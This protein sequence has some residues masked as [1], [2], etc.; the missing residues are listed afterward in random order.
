MSESTK[1]MSLSK[2]KGAAGKPNFVFLLADDMGFGTISDDTTPFMASLASKAVTLDNYYSQET[3]TPARAALLTGRYPI[4]IGVQFYEQ[5]VA[6]KGGLPEGETTIADILQNEGYTTYMLGKW[7]LGNASPRQLPTSR[8]FDYFLGFLDAYNHY[9]TKLNPDFPDFMDFMYA[10]STCYYKYDGDD[11][12]EYS[13][14]IFQNAAVAS[15]DG[16]DFDESPMF[17]YL[18]MQAARAPFDDLSDDHEHGMDDSYL[19]E[20]GQAGVQ[21]YITKNIDGTIQQQYFKAVAVMDKA[22]ENIYNAL[23]DKGVLDNTYI[24][25]ASDNGGCPTA[26]GR[27]YPLRGTKGSLFEGGTKVEAFIYSPL[28]SSKVQGSTYSNLFHV[29]DWLPT[30]LSMAEVGYVRYGTYA[31]NGVSHLKAITS[32]DKAPR[33]YLLYNYYYDPSSPTV[34]LWNGKAFAVRNERYKL[35]HTYDSPMS[36]AWYA[37]NQKMNFDDDLAD[38]D[39][40]AQFSAVRGGEFKYFLFDLKT[41]PTETTNLY[42]T[43][44][45]YKAIQ[46]ELY[47]ALT[48]LTKTAAAYCDSGFEEGAEPAWKENDNYIVP[49]IDETDRRLDAE[50]PS[51]SSPSSPSPRGHGGRRLGVKYPSNCG[52]WSGSDSAADADESVKSIQSKNMI[53]ITLSPKASVGRT[54]AGLFSVVARTAA[55]KTLA[56]LYGTETVTE[57]PEE[58]AESVSSPVRAYARGYQH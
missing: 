40:C 27:N 10:D 33:S 50:A 36:G 44:A 54:S 35:M 6:N 12:A 41:D 56:A 22:M 11:L 34:D 24:L 21:K 25:F 1:I 30:V 8:G 48:D 19:A 39:G 51:A 37:D 26:G 9:W 3:C 13:T 17:L 53:S 57:E 2:N 28:L 38:F 4:S 5:E 7:N 20:V 49:W 42:D 47:D 23:D 58:E 52:M 55:A 16:H 31:L 32:G 45:A 15:I 43:T 18:S 14:T 46:E 29:S